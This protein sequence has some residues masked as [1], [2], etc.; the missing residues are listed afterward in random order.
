M[1][2]KRTLF[3]L[4]GCWLAAFLPC[5]TQAQKVEISVNKNNILIGEQIEYGL[6]V[7]VTSERLRVHFVIPDSIPHF[8]IIKRGEIT[9]LPGDPLSFEQV[10]TFT[11]FD[12][13]SWVFP[14]IPVL[15]TNGAQK[16]NLAS[17]TVLVQVG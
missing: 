5:V 10:I 15:V 1:M 7:V 13:G 3:V 17:S 9:T 12:S 16:M 14:S 2:I 8:D 6:K 4:L 11:S